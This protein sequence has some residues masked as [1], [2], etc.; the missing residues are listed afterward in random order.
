MSKWERV[1]LGDVMTLDI[2]VE[3]VDADA[4]YPVVGVLNRG[5]GLL[6]RDAVS[7][8]ATRYRTLNVIRPGRVVYSRLKA[9]EG[10]ITVAPPGL[11]QA[12]ASQEFPTFT[13][14]TDLLV[15]YFALV[16][17]TQALWDDLQN[18]ST[19]MGG[20]RE[21]VKPG[22]FLSIR[23]DLPPL[24]EQ[25]RIV[26]VMA[27]VDAQVTAL[28]EDLQAGRG[29]IGPL[30]ES[31]LTANSNWPRV[32][33]GEVGEFRRGRRFT[34]ADYTESGLGVIHYSHIHTHFGPVATAAASYV[35]EA[36]R[37]RLRLASR[38]DVVIAATS[39]DLAGVGKATVWLGEDDVAVHDD[40]QIFRHRLDPLFAS[41]LFTS[42]TFQS[43]KVPYAEGTKVTRISGADLA[44]IVVPIPPMDVQVRIG[45]ALK[46]F[47]EQTDR[48]NAELTAVRTLRSTLLSALLTQSLTIPE[49]YDAMLET[50]S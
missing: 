25:R 41:F 8:S 15:S 48:L 3:E 43:Q 20:R 18:V 4:M 12:Y 26:D 27:A 31:L 19:G 40:A 21:R 46:A 36:H 13:C 17:T 7:G 11:G 14:G 29:C 22:D 38:G 34:K 50:A 37:T 6:Y 49:A 16:T 1:R 45:D 42:H 39:E 33:L 28:E 2:E 23:M 35:S 30:A 5:R 44:R 47:S 9:F 10:A 24:A 32:P